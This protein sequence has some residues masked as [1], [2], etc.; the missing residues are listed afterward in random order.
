MKSNF[1]QRELKIDMLQPGKRRP[2]AQAGQ[3]ELARLAA[4]IK[5]R[6]RVGF[7]VVQRL[8]KKRILRSSKSSRGSVAGM[9]RK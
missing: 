7:I 1:E 3:V 2:W 9:Q 6:G 8:E 4:L 5:A